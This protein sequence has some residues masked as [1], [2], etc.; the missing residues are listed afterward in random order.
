MTYYENILTMIIFMISDKDNQTKYIY[1][2]L[3]YVEV[4]DLYDK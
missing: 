2:W 4:K 1:L 3:F